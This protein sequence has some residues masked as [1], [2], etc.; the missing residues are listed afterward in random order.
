MKQGRIIAI[1]GRW[2]TVQD[3]EST[4]YL[5]ARNGHGWAVGQTVSYEYVN[6]KNRIR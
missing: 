2:L 6:G 1:K 4:V 5:M 3:G